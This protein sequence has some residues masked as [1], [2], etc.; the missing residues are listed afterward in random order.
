MLAQVPIENKGCE[1]T[2][3]PEV[4]KLLDIRGST[5][6]IDAIGTQAG[7]MEQIHKQGGN[8]I[9]TVKENQPETCVEINCFMDK[10]E[11]EA[12]K[13]R[14]GEKTDSGLKDYLAKYEEVSKTEKNRD[15]YEY[16][17]YKIC[18]D[19]SELPKSQKE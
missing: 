14:K 4:L 15:R 11:N 13:E 12:G 2:A 6:T 17:T 18:N 16:R 9:L 7:I 8:F 10:L 5:V 19:A 1:I 3:I